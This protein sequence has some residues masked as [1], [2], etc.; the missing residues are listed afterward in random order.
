MYFFFLLRIFFKFYFS[1]R[2]VFHISCLSSSLYF[3]FLSNISIHIRHKHEIFPSHHL[4]QLRETLPNYICLHHAVVKL[5]LSL[6]S[7]YLPPPLFFAFPWCSFPGVFAFSLI[8]SFPFK[9][10]HT[11]T[12]QDTHPRRQHHLKQH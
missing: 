8:Q 11:H 3:V 1:H 12:Q 2:L 4:S 7:D 10:T 9:E 6:S 5:F